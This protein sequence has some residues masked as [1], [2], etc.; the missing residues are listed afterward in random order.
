MSQSQPQRPRMYRGRGRGRSSRRRRYR[1]NS[2]NVWRR[3]RGGRQQSGA[4]SAADAAERRV[5]NTFNKQKALIDGIKLEEIFDA[6][7]VIIHFEDKFNFRIW[8]G[9]IGAAIYFTNTL[10][11][12]AVPYLDDPDAGDKRITRLIKEWPYLKIWC[13]Q[14]GEKR[15]S[16]GKM[17]RLKVTWSN[18]DEKDMRD[19]GCHSGEE[20]CLLVLRVIKKL[21]KS[22]EED[23]EAFI[24]NLGKDFNFTFEKRRYDAIG[25]KKIK[26]ANLYICP[27][28]RKTRS[29]N[30]DDSALKLKKVLVAGYPQ[31]H[32]TINRIGDMSR[33][34]S[35]G[36]ILTF[37][38]DVNINELSIRFRLING[39][40]IHFA[41]WDESGPSN[42]DEEKEDVSQDDMLAKLR[43]EKI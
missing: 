36:A 33:F 32:I 39:Q 13:K 41:E 15:N 3:G 31:Y 30:D 21:D 25:I 27:R 43:S 4:I 12:D 38:G 19:S 10:G 1:G 26:V 8:N 18:D 29:Y 11:Q 22:Y 23:N 34:I 5:R 2:N 14:I 9:R 6:F 28:L 7:N 24:E 40:R 17:V 16:G 37:S 42:R 20:F 35:N